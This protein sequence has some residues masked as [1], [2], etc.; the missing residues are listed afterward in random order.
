MVEGHHGVDVV[1][2][3]VVLLNEGASHVAVAGKLNLVWSDGVNR[4]QVGCAVVLDDH[5]VLVVGSGGQDGVNVA[6]ELDVVVRQDKVESVRVAGGVVGVSW[7]VSVVGIVMVVLRLLVSV[8]VQLTV[9]GEVVVVMDALV[10]VQ[11]VL[12][13]V[14]HVRGVAVQVHLWGGHVVHHVVVRSH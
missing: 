14:V 4:S 6:V 8:W 2:G 10:D 9:V 5:T 3:V 1:V 7:V 11:Q 13:V 12:V